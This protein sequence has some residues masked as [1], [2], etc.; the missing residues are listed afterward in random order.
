MLRG[1][2]NGPRGSCRPTASGAAGRLSKELEPEAS[3]ASASRTVRRWE[4]AGRTLGGSQ[5]CVKA[6]PATA[7]VVTRHGQAEAGVVMVAFYVQ[8]RTRKD[9]M[10]AHILVVEASDDVRTLIADVLTA[11]GHT[12][13]CAADGAEVLRLL[14]R[15][16]LF[17]LILSDLT[18]PAIEGAQLYWEIGARWPQLASRLICVTDGSSAG[19]IDHPTLRATSVP[20]LVKPFLP[21]RLLGVVRSALRR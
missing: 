16:H 21:E 14:E 7:L 8:T 10:P 19:A 9:T 11:D 5:A 2:L 12:V 3:N 15:E 20:I 18:L 1:A 4:L 17:D 13:Q 6:I